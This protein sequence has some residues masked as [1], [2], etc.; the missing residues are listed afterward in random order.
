MTSYI[1]GI[2]AYCDRWCERCAFTARCSTFAATVAVAM[3]GDVHEGFE[4]ALGETPEQRESEPPPDLEYSEPTPEEIAA[5]ARL[6]RE[7]KER[8]DETRLMKLAWAFSIDSHRWTAAR[9]EFARLGADA[10]LKEAIDVALHDA[11]FIGAKI[12][13]ALSGRD[14]SRRD[15]DWDEHPV[16]NDWNGSAKIAL[17]SLERSEPAWRV[18]AQATGDTMPANLAD[19]LRDLRTEVEREFPTARSFVRP[20]F[21]TCS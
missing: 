17:I 6:E 12:R 19:Q 13:R 18:I 8:I 2:S 7:R 16:Q 11:Y 1:D 3:C 15:D 10:V 21:D 14:R 20:G 5:V 4:L 9:C